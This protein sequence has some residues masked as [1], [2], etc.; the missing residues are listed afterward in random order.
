VLNSGEAGGESLLRE[1][2][3]GEEFL[4]VEGGAGGDGVESPT[5]HS[6]ILIPVRSLAEWR[7]LLSEAGRAS[8]LH[9]IASSP[10][11]IALLLFT[12]AWCSACKTLL[13]EVERLSSG[14]RLQGMLAAIADVDEAED[15]AAEVG[16]TALPTVFIYRAGGVASESAG[17]A[18][19]GKLGE[20]VGEVRGA[21]VAALRAMLGEV[22]GWG[23][24]G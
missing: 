23:A 9:G 13:P 4:M 3:A 20:R 24:E 2:E 18:A 17:G 19:G 11:G 6:R 10:H 1:S 5:E 22:G 12:A 21:D 14:L 8:S 16:V 7:R 15:L